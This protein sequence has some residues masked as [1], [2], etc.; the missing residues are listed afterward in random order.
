MSWFLPKREAR[1][2][3]IESAQFDSCVGSVC[4]DSIC[5]GAG[6][7]TGCRGYICAGGDFDSAKCSEGESVVF[8]YKN[9]QT[10]FQYLYSTFPNVVS[11][12]VGVKCTPPPQ[13]PALAF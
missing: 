1:A 12:I 9:D 13:E 4:S 5:R 6:I 8:Y 2:R 3:A 11:P 7:S 10:E